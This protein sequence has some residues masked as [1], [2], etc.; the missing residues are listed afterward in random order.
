MDLAGLVRRDVH[1]RRSSKEE[2]IE[3]IG[4]GGDGSRPNPSISNG[5][6]LELKLFVL[7]GSIRDWAEV[8]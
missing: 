6:Y 1:P 8:F 2:G 3:D 5:Y 7:R 4:C